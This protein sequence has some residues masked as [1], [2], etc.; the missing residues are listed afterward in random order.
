MPFGGRPA[1]K[2]WARLNRQWKRTFIIFLAATFGSI[3]FTV[4][5]WDAI[6][7]IP[8]RWHLPHLNPEP[9]SSL[10]S[11]A[12]IFRLDSSPTLQQH[13]IDNLIQHADRE[14]QQLLDKETTGVSQAAKSYRNRR[15][16]HPPPGFDH[17]VAFAEEHD[18]LMIEDMFDRIYQDLDPFWAIGSAEIRSAA[19]A[20][21]NYIRIKNGKASRS[22]DKKP[23]MDSYLKMIQKIAAFLPDV[24]IPINH[25]DESRVLVSWET[26][27][28]KLAMQRSSLARQDL[29]RPPLVDTFTVLPAS[30]DPA[31]LPPFV[32]RPPY[33]NLAKHACPPDSQA[34]ESEVDNDF[35][36]PPVFPNTHPYGTSY[37]YVQNWTV[38]QDICSHPHLRNMHGTFVEPI[39]ISTSTSL[40]PIF[41]G[42]KLQVNNDILLP[43]AMYWSDKERFAASKKH[44]AWKDKRNEVFWRGTGSGGRNTADNWTRFQRHRLVS[45]LNATQVEMTLKA[46][47]KADER[48]RDGLPHNF[49]SPKSTLYPLVSSKLGLL[50]DWIRSLSNVAFFWLECFPATEDYGCSYTGSWYRRGRPVSMQRMYLNKYLPDVDGNS[51][52]GRFRAFLMSHSLPIKATIYT[53]WHDSR[54]IPWKHFVPMDNTFMDLWGILE[55]FFQN[56]NQAEKIGVEGKEW[57]YK[58]LRKED[59]LAYVYRLL[60]EY[61]RLNDPNREQM[62]FGQDLVSM[63]IV[64]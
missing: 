60:L 31:E 3:I 40:I 2:M 16:R 12:D 25:M 20:F 27:A 50:P 56:D 6:N 41:S 34:R 36:T 52:S 46:S 19:A 47:D 29:A 10:S 44:L 59:M 1:M 33:W 28:D 32:R 39:S 18:C 14:Y 57:A 23:F 4:Y 35:S 48:D 53:E 13:P 42:S 30:Y 5:S 62:G 11:P 37:G 26:M 22:A 15:G 63:G 24:D 43:A 54:L 7:E 55:Y 58:V 8:D 49:P 38:S 51:F 45:M 61:A 64:T 17:W 21:P 9:A